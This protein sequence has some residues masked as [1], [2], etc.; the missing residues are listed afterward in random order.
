MA[1]LIPTQP[2]RIAPQSLFTF[3]RE[4]YNLGKV[5][6]MDTWPFGPPIM[7]VSDP[8]ISD[9]F[10]VKQ[11]LPKHPLTEDFTEPLGGRMNLVTYYGQQ[12]KTWRSAFN[13]GFS[14]AHLMTMVPGIVDDVSVF[15][16]ILE[17]KARTNELFRLEKHATR[18]TIDI[19]LKVVLDLRVDSQ[20]GENELVSAFESQ[21]RW[22]PR[23][24]MFNPL[25]LINIFRP[26]VLRWNK[27]RM[28]T[29][30]TKEL[31]KRFA[32]RGSRGKTKHVIDL[33]LETYW[34]ENKSAKEQTGM[35]N[36][37]LDR[38]FKRAALDNIEIFIFAGHDTSSSVICYALYHLSRNQDVLDAVRKEHDEVF[39]TDV[40]ITADAIKENPH[41]ISKLD[42][43]L[44]VIKEALRL[45]PPAST[46]RIGNKEY[47]FR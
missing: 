32:T 18:L 16:E 23:G 31:E 30:L 1:S 19:I 35:T 2:R 5:F 43:T 11:S 8:A 29:Y 45:H 17:Q 37:L 4:K 25:E 10:T 41:L 34:K 9:Q 38:T 7:V 40:A 22:L 27:R 46:V 39:G 12:W 44:A 15:C 33:A 42:W 47:V 26:I 3:V 20:R 24:A 28:D 14:F 13:P 36:P 6:Y 21:V